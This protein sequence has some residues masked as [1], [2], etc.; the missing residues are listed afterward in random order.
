MNILGQIVENK[1]KEIEDFKK[2][3]SVEEMKRKIQNK[4]SSFANVFDERKLGIIAEIKIKSPSGGDLIEE[5]RFKTEDRII[6]IA[7]NLAKEYTDAGADAISIVTDA[8]YFGGNLLM[9]QDA[10]SVTSIPIFQKDFV[11]DEIQIYSSKLLGASALL[12]IGRIL[13]QEELTKFV[14]LCFEIGLEPIVEIYNEQDLE[15]AL[16]TRVKFIGVNA[17][18]LST[19]KIDIEKAC[20]IMRSISSERFIIGFSGIKTKEEAEKYKSAGV[21]AILVGTNLLKVN[22]KKK[23]IE[24]LKI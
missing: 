5:V 8:K 10:C 6:R 1:K 13:A 22:D 9:V 7:K 23:F 3:I 21:K 2:E 18:N 17:R 14:D 4:K 12:L 15:K 19:F 16:A 24:S 11:I 20:T